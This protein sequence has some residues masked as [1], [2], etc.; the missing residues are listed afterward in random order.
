MTTNTNPT[1]LTDTELDETVTYD[2]DRLLDGLIES[3]TF[4]AE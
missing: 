2:P 3:V 4:V 1:A